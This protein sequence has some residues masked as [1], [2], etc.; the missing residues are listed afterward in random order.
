[1]TPARKTSRFARVRDDFYVEP[2]WVTAALLDRVEFPP[3]HDFRRACAVFWD[4]A[5]GTGT[6]PD[7]IN[8]W[9]G[10]TVAYRSDKVCRGGQDDSYSIDFLNWAGP[11]PGID[12]IITNPPYGLVEEFLKQA[13]SLARG[14]IAFLLPLKFLGSRKRGRL[15]RETPLAQVVV[16]SPRPRMAPGGVPIEGGSG[17]EDYAWFVWDRTSTGSR[18]TTLSWMDRSEVDEARIS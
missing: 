5:A 4:P 17:R 12:H 11:A 2:A 1:M 13:L 14:K 9:F 10:R 16:L 7:A 8:R 15:F 6:I 3:V 18:P